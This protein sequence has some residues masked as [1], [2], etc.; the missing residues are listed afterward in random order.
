MKQ[1]VLKVEHGALLECPVWEAHPRGRNWWAEISLD[2]RAPSGLARRFWERGRGPYYYIIP[3][4]LTPPVPVEVGADY[5][6]GSGR[7]KPSRWYGVVVSVT[8][9]SLVL[10]ESDNPR[11]AIE[12]AEQLRTPQTTSRIITVPVAT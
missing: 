3:R 6:T 2:P 4:D 9:A 1:V 7:K 5:Y 11:S 12:L 10:Y 8:S